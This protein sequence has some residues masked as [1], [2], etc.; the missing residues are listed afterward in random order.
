MGQCLNQGCLT[1]RDQGYIQEATRCLHPEMLGSWAPTHAG[2]LVSLEKGAPELMLGILQDEALQPMRVL[3]SCLSGRGISFGVSS[4][5][6]CYFHLRFD[7]EHHD[8]D[9]PTAG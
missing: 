1:R 5:L 4:R 2:S 9:R 7:N 3:T 6:V 8:S